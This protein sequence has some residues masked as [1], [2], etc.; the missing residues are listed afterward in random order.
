MRFTGPAFFF[1][2]CTMVFSPA[3]AG[4]Y[5]R[6]DYRESYERLYETR[7]ENFISTH[8]AE[9]A[10]P[11]TTAEIKLPESSFDEYSLYEWTKQKKSS[12]E[13]GLIKTPEAK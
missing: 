11:P 1:S 9:K 6:K 2:V 12:E 7:N 10:P 5:K 13:G 3:H 4:D 8:P